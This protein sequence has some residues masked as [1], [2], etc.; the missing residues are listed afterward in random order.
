M[1]TSLWVLAG[2]MLLGI[3]GAEGA[4]EKKPAKKR[5]LVITES[6]GYRHG[7]V[8]RQGDQLSLVEKTFIELGNKSGMFEAV[9]SQDSR[10]DIT[11][12]NLKNFD[13]VWF[14][15]TGELPLSDVQ[16]SDL[17][18]F[19][20]SGKGFGGSHSATDTFY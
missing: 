8:T 17:L 3:V 19:V 10:K 9:C 2:I 1:R 7:C 12:E 5:L 18:A 11:A 20:R 13:A 15:T 14:Y 4:G 6:K 16:K